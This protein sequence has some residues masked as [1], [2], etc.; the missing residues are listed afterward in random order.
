MPG[1]RST[2]ELPFLPTQLW[3]ELFIATNPLGTAAGTIALLDQVGFKAMGGERMMPREP[4]GT[5]LR[6]VEMPD[7]SDIVYSIIECEA[8]RRVTFALVKQTG[9]AFNYH[10]T[11]FEQPR[12]TFELA[13]QYNAMN[14]CV[15]TVVAFTSDV[16][17]T[18]HSAKLQWTD[19]THT[20]KQHFE[21]STAEWAAGMHKRGHEPLLDRVT[22]NFPERGLPSPTHSDLS[23]ASTADFGTS[24]AKGCLR[25]F[26]EHM[27]ER[28]R[29]LLKGGGKGFEHQG[30]NVKA[31]DYQLPRMPKPDPKPDPTPAPLA[32]QPLN[33]LLAKFL[34]GFCIP[35]K[36]TAAA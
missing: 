33:E 4:D 32:Q 14:E 5:G 35:W 9:G 30:F 26:E 3:H 34:G 16:R 11:N 8:P 19:D 2:I 36:A 31:L 6:K 7:G 27:T 17:A 13:P 1:F 18:V 22:A 25:C 20:V 29:M 28:E 12:F 24:A 15:G 10:G 21:R 23:N